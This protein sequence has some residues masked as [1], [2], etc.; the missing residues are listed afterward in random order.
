[1]PTGYDVPSGSLL[2]PVEQEAA[3]EV[4]AYLQKHRRAGNIGPDA[5]ITGRKIADG[6]NAKFRTKPGEKKLSDADIRAFINWLRAECMEPIASSSRGYYYAHDEEEIK[7]T[8]QTLRERI[9][10]MCA[11]YNGMARRF[12][13]KQEQPTLFD[14]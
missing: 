6:F 7:P 12:G 8:L 9:S 3:K 14:A 2:T 13:H 5:P 11:A 4:L 1:M 10:A